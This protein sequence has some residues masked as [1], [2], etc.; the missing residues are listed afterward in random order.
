MEE[1][2]LR[3]LDQS[4]NI[5]DVQ[6]TPGSDGGYR[7]SFVNR[8]QSVPVKSE[9]SALPVGD[10]GTLFSLSVTDPI[11][12]AGLWVTGTTD[13]LFSLKNNS[14]ELIKLKISQFNQ[15]SAILLTDPIYIS[16]GT[17]SIEVTNIGIED[18]DY[19]SIH[20]MQ[21]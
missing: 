5:R 3:F 11:R 17:L 4:S 15:D 2:L 9:L 18:G 8:G 6:I 7:L 1:F 20:Y 12:I 19:E 21:T 14:N 16:S 13:G 10:T